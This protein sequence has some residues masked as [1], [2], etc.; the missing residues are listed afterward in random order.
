MKHSSSFK[1]NLDR[2]LRHLKKIAKERSFETNPRGLAEVQSYIE[3]E[4]RSYGFEVRQIPFDFHGQTF[5]NL[6]ARIRTNS[7][8]SRLIIGAHFDA[9]PG[10]P[11][12][13]DNASGVACLLEAA[14]IFAESGGTD[15]VEFVAFNLEECGMIGSRAYARALKKKRERVLGMLSLEMVGFVSEKK[16]SQKMPIFL[17][18]FYPDTGNFIGLV[19][20]TRS[21]K[22]LEEVRKIFKSV[23]A[24]AVESL[25]LPAN[26]WVF[27]DARL[28]DHSP[29]WDEG[30]PALLVTDTSFFRNPH[31]HTVQDRIET[32]D[33]KFLARVTEATVRTILSG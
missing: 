26:G 14:R 5:F 7:T 23:N 24:L 4:F 21:V 2:L 32:L 10:S 33:L 31:Y 12:A 6:A 22:L 18:P 28:S 9:V 16:G 11:G 1:P 27:P 15:N 25:T 30:F 3:Q 19:A 17:R 13:D 29:F 8:K 20:N